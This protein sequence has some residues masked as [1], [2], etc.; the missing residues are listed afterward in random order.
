MQTHSHRDRRA[1]QHSGDFGRR[2]SFPIDQQQQ[3]DHAGREPRAPRA[4]DRCAGLRPPRSAG[5]EHAA[6]RSACGVG[7]T[8]G[9][10]LRAPAAPSHRA[11]A[12]HHPRPALR[13]GASTRSKRPPRPHLP[14]RQASASANGSTRRRP[15]HVAGTGIESLAASPAHHGRL[16]GAVKPG[17]RG[18]CCGARARACRRGTGLRRRPPPH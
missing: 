13:Q 8:H 16:T 14:R 2:E 10:G 1:M 11:K 3:L 18:R 4:P 5:A 9:P 7:C 15:P 17:P 12:A 6:S